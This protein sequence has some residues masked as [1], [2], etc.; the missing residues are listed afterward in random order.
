MKLFLDTN[1]ILDY[2]EAREKG[3]FAKQVLKLAQDGKECECVTASSVTD[4]LYLLT[5][6]LIHR[7]F[8]D[9][10]FV[11]SAGMKKGRRSDLFLC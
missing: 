1:I 9:F 2:L 5:K 4:I 7:I 10:L 11:L 3:L 8:C 6:A